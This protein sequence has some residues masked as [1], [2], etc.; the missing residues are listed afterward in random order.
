M[1][2]TVNLQLIDIPK[3][4]DA[5]EKSHKG[6]Y[7]LINRC[8]L[9]LFRSC[10]QRLK[11]SQINELVEYQPKGA[12]YRIVSMVFDVVV[13]N[14]AV[15]FRVFCRLSV[16]KM[17]TM[18]LDDFLEEVVNDILNKEVNLHNYVDYKHLMRH[19]ECNLLPE[20]SIIWEIEE[21]PKKNPK[22]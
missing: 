6:R 5:V 3:L 9:K 7:E 22:K 21:N 20:W 14:L 2:T 15:N 10:N 8:L 12:G 1:R 11:L 13:Y 17:I 19:N 4:I 16:S 18:A